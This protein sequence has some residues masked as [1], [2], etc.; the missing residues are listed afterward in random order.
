MYCKCSVFSVVKTK[1][2][3]AKFRVKES[4]LK[5]LRVVMLVNRRNKLKGKVHALSSTQ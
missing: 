2:V 4:G 1:R 3:V 5:K